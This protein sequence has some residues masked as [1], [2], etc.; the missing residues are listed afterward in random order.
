MIVNEQQPLMSNEE[1][2]QLQDVLRT[3]APTGRAFLTSARE[4]VSEYEILK[5]EVKA[6]DTDL[7]TAL[8]KCQEL[9][10]E[11]GRHENTGLFFLL[12]WIVTAMGWILYIALR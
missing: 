2:N 5:K 9:T 1:A 4:L 6:K 7:A 11:R 3:I 12:G 10:N 8:K